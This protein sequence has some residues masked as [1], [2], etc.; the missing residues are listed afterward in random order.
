MFDFLMIRGWLLMAGLLFSLAPLAA[1]AQTVDGLQGNRLADW[2]ADLTFAQARIPALHFDAYNTISAGAFQAEAERM[3]AALALR[4]EEEAIVAAMRWVASIGDGHTYFAPKT[5]RVYPIQVY[6]FADGD[7]ITNALPAMQHLVGQRLVAVEGVPLDSVYQ[8]IRPLVAADSESQRLSWLPLYLTLHE[9]LRGTGLTSQEMARFTVADA[10]GEQ[11]DVVLT[12]LDGA[13]YLDTLSII[14]SAIAPYVSRDF[15]IFL[16]F[17]EALPPQPEGPLH[18]RRPEEPYWAQ[19]LP[20]ARTLYV[21]YN[22]V[23]NGV[24]PL[25][26]FSAR[27]AERLDTLAIDKVVVDVRHNIG[28]NNSLNGPFVRALAE[29]PRLQAPGTLYAILGR[30]TF[31]AATDFVASLENRTPVV[32]AGEPT[33]GS[34]N[35]YGNPTTLTLPETGHQVRVS[36]FFW[37][38]SVPTDRRV[39][40]EPHLA[41]A[42]T[43]RDYFE[44]RD[45]VLQ[46]VLQHQSPALPTPFLPDSIAT[47]LMGTYLYEPDR[48]MQVQKDEQGL[49]LVIPGFIEQALPYQGNGFL[50]TRIPGVAIRYDMRTA[51]SVLQLYDT[52]QPLMAVPQSYTPPLLALN[53]QTIWISVA[54]LKAL[55]QQNPAHRVVTESYLNQLGYRYLRAANTEVALALFQLN[56]SLYPA[57]A[58]VYD[59]AGEAYLQAG[60]R[61][62]ARYHYRQALVRDPDL[63]SAKQALETIKNGGS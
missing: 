17:A 38:H 53:E 50:E 24:E 30:R 40:T 25:A 37:E 42:L 44:G 1:H 59:S 34:P 43:S 49:R 32:F 14:P 8:R 16:N 52:E 63:Q 13:T 51:K 18:L 3:Q 55:H 10:E 31:S 21:A 48:V 29:H 33:G 56:M 23:R 11:T 6:R 57:S 41:V 22:F 47:A 46:A 28:G 39:S 27:L 15:S 9:V 61:E 35:H 36:R 26:A 5:F 62:A 2:Q 7:Y 4:S 54:F 19:Y 45:P 60:D 12:P 58:N 20:E